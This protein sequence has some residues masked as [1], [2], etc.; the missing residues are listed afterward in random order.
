WR[1]VCAANGNEVLGELGADELVFH[2]D[3]ATCDGY[4]VLALYGDQSS[5]I[6]YV[7]QAQVTGN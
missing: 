7:E 6:A 2:D 5:G 1:V 3:S 4:A